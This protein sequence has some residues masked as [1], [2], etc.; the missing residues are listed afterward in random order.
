MRDRTVVL[1]FPVLHDDVCRGPIAIDWEPSAS[2][3]LA[4]V[5]EQPVEAMLAL[6]DLTQG[7]VAQV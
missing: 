6:A 5:T 1:Q 7:L 3:T 2:P 4:S